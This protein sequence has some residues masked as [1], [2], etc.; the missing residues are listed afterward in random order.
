MRGQFGMPNLSLPAFQKAG[1]PPGTLV[2]TATLLLSEL[3]WRSRAAN[4]SNVRWEFRPNEAIDR[5][6]W[7][8]RAGQNIT[9]N[10]YFIEILRPWLGTARIVLCERSFNRAVARIRRK[11]VDI[12]VD[13]ASLNLIPDVGFSSVGLGK[14]VPQRIPSTM[15]TI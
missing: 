9:V 7:K 14:R 11:T 4:L 15:L 13:F 2:E 12:N 10:A 1:P 6:I 3:G 5:S 8:W